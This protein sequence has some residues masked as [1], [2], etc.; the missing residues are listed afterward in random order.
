MTTEE[1]I[2]ELKKYPSHYE[3]QAVLTGGGEVNDK[4]AEFCGV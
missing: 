4:M 2:K 3:V 1:L